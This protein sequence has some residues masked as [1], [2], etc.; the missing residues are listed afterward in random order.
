MTDDE[1]WLTKPPPPG[2][3][4]DY[5]DLPVEWIGPG[6]PGTIC[7]AHVVTGRWWWPERLWLWKAQR[8]RFDVDRNLRQAA[9][10]R[11]GLKFE[12]G[13]PAWKWFRPGDV[14]DVMAEEVQRRAQTTTEHGTIRVMLA[15]LRIMT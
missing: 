14:P 3:E 2:R 12:P 6:G 10:D 9:A 15:W 8:E 11:G 13:L 5:L 7:I 4:A 1:S